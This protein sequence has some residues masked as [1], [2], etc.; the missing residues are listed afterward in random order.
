TAAPISLHVSGAA[1]ERNAR[2]GLL[3]DANDL[4]PTRLE[5]MDVTALAEGEGTLG[6]VAQRTPTPAG[7]DAGVTREGDAAA[8]DAGFTGGISVVGIMM[9]PWLGALPPPP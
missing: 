4:A 7:W 2:A 6:V 3:I 1:L 5:L 8:H 9:P